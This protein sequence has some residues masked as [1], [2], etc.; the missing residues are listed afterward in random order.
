V[1]I[2][3]S[4]DLHGIFYREEGCIL[5]ECTDLDVATFGD[6]HEKAQEM[7]EDAILCWFESCLDRNSIE[8]AF[9]ELGI[10]FPDWLRNEIADRSAQNKPPLQPV[11]SFDRIEQEKWTAKITFQ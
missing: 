6:N 1:V 5:S 7:T 2:L 9:L 10:Q 3:N 11:F 4:I 8:A